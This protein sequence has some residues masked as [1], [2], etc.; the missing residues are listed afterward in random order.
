MKISRNAVIHAGPRS[1]SWD[2]EDQV[3]DADP[4]PLSADEAQEWRKK[5]RTV[6]PWRIVLWQA[7]VGLLVAIAFAVFWDK[8]S[9]MSAAYGALSVVLPSAL[10]VWGVFRPRWADTA[11]SAVRRFALWELVK[12]GLTLA[13]LALAPRWIGPVNWL[14]LVAG[15]V[16]TMKVLG[17]AAWLYAKRPNRTVSN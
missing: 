9:A 15:F 17:V 12:L 6:A 4:K 3:P 2:G 11:T 1:P 8:G 7:L 16:V 13:M 5:H 10:M 14:A